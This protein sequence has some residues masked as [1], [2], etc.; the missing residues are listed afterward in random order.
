VAPHRDVLPLIS[1]EIAPRRVREPQTTRP[2]TGNAP[3]AIYADR[4]N[5]PFLGISQRHRKLGY[6]GEGR[7][8]PRR[9]F[10]TPRWLSV[11]AI[12][13]RSRHTYVRIELAIIQRV[14]L[15]QL[16]ENTAC[17]LDPVIKGSMPSRRI[18][19]PSSQVDREQHCSALQTIRTRLIQHVSRDIAIRVRRKAR[20]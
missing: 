3:Q 16:R 5:W 4:F 7:F 11:R 1:Q 10:H 14:F 20:I 2:I 9:G 15:H 6:P 13:P 8:G 19:V 12:H 17:V 18:F